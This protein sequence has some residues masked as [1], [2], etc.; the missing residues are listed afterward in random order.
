MKEIAKRLLSTVGYYRLMRRAKPGTTLLILMYHDLASDRQAGLTAALLREKI[1][2]TQFEAHLRVLSQQCRIMSVEEAVREI[3]SEGKLLCDTVSITFDDGYRSVY[4]IAYPLLRDY[5]VPA[6]V[7]LTTDW[8]N[9]KM[10]LWWEQLADMIAAC[11][12]ERASLHEVETILSSEVRPSLASG[13]DPLTKRIALHRHAAAHMRDLGDDDIKSTIIRLREVLCR[14]GSPGT[15]A[16][17][18]SWTQVSELAENGICFGSHTCSHLNVSH[19]PLE[20][21]EAEITESTSEIEQHTGMRV[22]GF[23]YPYG[24]D[25]GHYGKVEPILSRHDFRYACTAIPGNNSSGSNLYAL[26][27][28]TL[29]L[30]DSKSLLERELMLDL[31][32]KGTP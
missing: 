23:A 21:I 30:T 10:S 11:D 29:P 24:Q 5:N 31:A 32:P 12:L 20:L 16:E 2:R 3:R 1:A 14:D 27:R 6:T 15:T 9:G 19:A 28:E 25:I 7:Y 4:D 13:S 22:E 26:L 8:I 18:L 17:P